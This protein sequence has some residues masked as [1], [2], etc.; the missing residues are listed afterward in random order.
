MMKVAECEI[1]FVAEVVAIISYCN[2][3]WKARRKFGFS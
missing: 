2:H 1:F 3:V